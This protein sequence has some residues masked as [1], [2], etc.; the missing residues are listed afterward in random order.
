MDLDDLASFQ[1]CLTGPWE[2]E[3]SLSLECLVLDF[4]A[5]TDVDLHDYATFQTG[6]TGRDE[7]NTF[8]EFSDT[9]GQDNWYYGYCEPLEDPDGVYDTSN[10]IE[11]PVY[12]LLEPSHRL[13]W[14]LGLDD[15]VPW[16]RVCRLGG[17]PSLPEAGSHW[18]IR[19]WSTEVEGLVTITGHLSMEDV[20]SH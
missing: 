1:A 9:Q 13:C 10:F 7:A 2:T 17:S 3:E 5:D 15:S 11:L 14:A 20:F 8:L 4:D 6:F 16:T 12:G 19:R 18:S